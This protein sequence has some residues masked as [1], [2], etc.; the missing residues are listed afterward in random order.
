MVLQSFYE[1]IL[2]DHTIEMR[3]K[4]DQTKSQPA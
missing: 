3:K 2:L 4:I 1:I